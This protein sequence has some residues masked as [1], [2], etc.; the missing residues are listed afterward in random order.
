MHEAEERRRERKKEKK[1]KKKRKENI[2]KMKKKKNMSRTSLP[3]RE[4]NRRVCVHSRE[5]V[6]EFSLTRIDAHT[7][8]REMY[9]EEE[10]I[11]HRYLQSY[12]ALSK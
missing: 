7:I 4:T 1:K 6:S 9:E 3:S 2:K 10:D 12:Y 11:N 5:R 8:T